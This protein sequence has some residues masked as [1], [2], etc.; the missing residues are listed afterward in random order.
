MNI[1]DIQDNL[2]NLPEQA[3]MREMQQPTGSAPQ[4]L[5]LGELKRRK[6]MRDDYNRQ[7]NADVKTVAEEVVTAAG[8][9]QEGIMQMSRSLNPICPCSIVNYGGEVRIRP[10]TT[11]VSQQVVSI[12]ISPSVSNTSFR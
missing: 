7:K 12:C 8:A 11:Q 1:I 3:L 10:L 9:P 6:Q 5:V 4:F 2:K